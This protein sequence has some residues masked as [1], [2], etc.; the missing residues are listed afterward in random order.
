VLGTTACHNL[1]AA[2]VTKSDAAFNALNG[3]ALDVAFAT[4]AFVTT[5]PLVTFSLLPPPLLAPPGSTLQ[6][7][8]VLPF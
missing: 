5:A 1:V 4:T 7:F 3:S 6:R 8:E 2:I